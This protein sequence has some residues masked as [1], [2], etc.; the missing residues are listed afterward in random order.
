MDIKKI[1]DR[2]HELPFRPFSIHLADG[3]DIMIQHPDF[4]ALD[5]EETELVAFAPDGSMKIVNLDLMTSLDISRPKR[6]KK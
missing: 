1:R 3:R 5:P 2:L 4:V 6:N